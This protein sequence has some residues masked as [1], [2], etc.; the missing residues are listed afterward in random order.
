MLK[1]E[2]F[3]DYNRC[4]LIKLIKFFYFSTPIG[5]EDASKYP[6]LFAELIGHGW[7]V[8]ELTKLASGNILRVLNEVE[9]VRDKKK[10]ENILPRE[11]ILT[12][13]FENPFKCQSI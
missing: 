9:A 8:E 2:Q 1:I 11:D 12:N 6:V 4:Y 5:L 10:N 13:R 7:S 3:Y